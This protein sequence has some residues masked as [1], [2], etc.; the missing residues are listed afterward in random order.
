MEINIYIYIKILG[1][2][3]FSV[4]SFKWNIKRREQ[5]KEKEKG[6]YI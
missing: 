1:R 2:K 4:V 6:I 3:R 5:G